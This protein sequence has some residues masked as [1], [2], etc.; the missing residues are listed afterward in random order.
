MATTKTLTPT[1]QTISIPELSDSP[2]M[3][4]P[5]EAISKEADAINALSEHIEYVA[6]GTE[7]SNL[8]NV[9]LNAKGR[10][11]LAGAVSP[12]GNS[13]NCSF[14]CIGSANYRTITIW[15]T[16]TG[17]S[18]TTQKNGSGVSWS[19]WISL[20]DRI[21]LT[22]T[23]LASSYITAN[24]GTISSGAI[25]KNIKTC[26][27]GVVLSGVSITSGVELLTVADGYGIR[28]RRPSYISVFNYDDGRPFNGCLYFTNNGKMTYYG[29]S[30]SNKN[31]YVCATYI[32]ES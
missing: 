7:I 2:D 16:S 25:E 8:D 26:M 22:E 1:N 11:S 29:D 20:S 10:I 24:K 17:N 4:V 18:W 12:S 6:T 15:S 19:S 3:S 14:L 31:I 13:L 21:A 27:L 9:P 30:I 28:P 32:G 5:A 23:F